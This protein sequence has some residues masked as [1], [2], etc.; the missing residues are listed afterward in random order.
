MSPKC[1]AESGGICSAT[2]KGCL[3]GL[4]RWCW[5]RFRGCCLYAGVG[6]VEK[7]CLRNKVSGK[8]VVFERVL[9][10]GKQGM[11]KVSSTESFEPFRKGLFLDASLS[12]FRLVRQGLP[13]NRKQLRTVPRLDQE[14]S[15]S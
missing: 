11:A 6:K 4:R 8:R 12:L 13:D 7:P 10:P 5:E 2:H 9:K 1:D 14:I 15:N 3:N